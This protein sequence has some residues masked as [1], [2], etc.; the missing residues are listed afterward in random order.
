[1]NRLIA[2]RVNEYVDEGMNELKNLKITERSIKE[3][4]G[5]DSL[6]H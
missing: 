6:I 3:N 5:F 1:M 2:K 4:Q